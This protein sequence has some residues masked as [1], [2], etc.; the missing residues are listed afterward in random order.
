MSGRARGTAKNSQIDSIP[1]W[2]FYKFDDNHPVTNGID[3]AA[4]SENGVIDVD[5]VDFV[6][7]TKDEDMAAMHAMTS[8]DI[9]YD[10]YAHFSTP[11]DWMR[12]KRMMDTYCEAIESNRHL[13]IDKIVLDVNCGIGILA[14]F[15][16]RAGA[17]HVY[18]IDKSNA[19][20]MARVVV[21][22]N[23]FADSITVIQ[24]DVDKIKLPVAQVD[25]IVS[26]IRWYVLYM[27]IFTYRKTRIL[28]VTE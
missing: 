3:H 12:D 17:K 11:G 19:V 9:F 5:S 7:P 13:F 8:R 15:A 14:M 2:D 23:D 10:P 18:A 27:P 24:G 21:A 6:Q 25:V 1:E 26:L 28:F 20:R 16:L 22:D 4:C